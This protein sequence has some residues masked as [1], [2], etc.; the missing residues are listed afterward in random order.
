M[1]EEKL[2]RQ[3]IVYMLCPVPINS[4]K[5]AARFI[6]TYFLFCIYIVYITIRV[7]VVCIKVIVDIINHVD[8]LAEAL[9]EC[10]VKVISWY[11]IM[12]TEEKHGNFT[13]TLMLGYSCFQ[14][15]F[16]VKSCVSEFSLTMNVTVRDRACYALIIVHWRYYV[17]RVSYMQNH[18]L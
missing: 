5:W 17:T 9:N 13:V 6:N 4:L 7:L 8:I 16:F 1:L 10:S 15:S 12:S 2:F 14:S 3:C 18:Y 11:F